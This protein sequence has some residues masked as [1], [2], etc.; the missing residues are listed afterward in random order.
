ME[1]AARKVQ[2]AELCRE[3]PKVE[4]HAHINGSLSKQTIKKL[5]EIKA[6]KGEL[7]SEVTDQMISCSDGEQKTLAECFEMFK[8]VHKIVDNPE[9]VY[10]ATKDVIREF[11]GDGVK[12][13]ELRTTPKNAGSMSK[14]MYMASVIQAIN[15]SNND[16]GLEILTRLLVSIDRQN[17]KT[18]ADQTVDLADK[19]KGMSDCVVG[20]DLSGNP[21]CGI[22]SDF[23]AAL[24]RAKTLGLRTA[25][26]LAETLEDKSE[27]QAV[28]DVNPDRIGHGTCL[29]PEDGGHQELV[30]FVA[31]HKIP[32]ELCLTSNVKGQTVKNYDVHHFQKWYEMGHPCVVCTDDKGIFGTCLSNEYRLTAETFQLD[33]KS[34][35]TLSENAIDFIFEGDQ[36]KKE[37][38]SMW[39]EKR[40][41]FE[42]KYCF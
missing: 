33:H 24:A 42:K 38:K 34:L 37:L 17:G 1:E 31:R 36:M 7:G 25:V 40:P 8:V 12:Y 15:E 28:L 29:L 10:E 6:A 26:H 11:A 41:E 27:T 21:N 20:I 18:V 5:I 3:M 39:Q 16:T 4:L 2:I 32:L 23:T 14:D 9:A 30:D 22:L 19:Y 13:L 35:W